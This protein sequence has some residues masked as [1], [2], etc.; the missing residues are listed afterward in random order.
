LR[1]AFLFQK[2]GSLMRNSRREFLQATSAAA[3]GLTALGRSVA[4]TAAGPSGE[5]G[6]A[7]QPPATQPVQVPKIKFGGV[8]IGRMVLGVNPF[9]GGAHYN[10]N[11]SACMGEFYTQDK[12]CEV[13]HYA[14]SFGIN[15]FNYV[16][17]GRV[18]GALAKFRDEGGEMY[19]IPQVTAKDDPAA[20]VQN[21]KPL[22]LQRRGEE[23]DAA[24]NKK[25]M[26][27]EREWCKKV[28]DLGVMVGVGT[29]RSEVIELI[30]EQ[31]WDVDFYAGCVYGRTRTEAE[32][33][34]LLNGELLEMPREIYIQS[35]PPRMY[36]VMQQTKK[37]CFAFKILAAGR[38]ADADVPRAFRTA[39][40]GIKPNDG[41]FVGYFPKRKDEIREN[42]ETM[43]AIASGA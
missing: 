19:L 3:L 39:M 15:A 29:H 38:V 37:P 26:T 21:L 27:S 32:W 5:K 35:D 11:Y 31:G 18:P 22:G 7:Q 40:E 20:L 10:Q 6:G 12:I 13:M 33:R 8:E 23:V 16:Q 17:M 41:L 24:F 30:E 4:Q 2:E 43:H 42:V 1:E 34:Q 28:R 25:D 14:N 36:K 9:L